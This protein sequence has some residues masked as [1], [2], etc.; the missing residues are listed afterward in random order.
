M[1]PSEELF[2]VAEVAM[3]SPRL[4][5]SKRHGIISWYDDGRRA[6]EEFCEPQWFAGFQKWW[7]LEHGINY[8]ALETAHMGD[9]RIGQGE[10]EEEALI[11]LLSCGE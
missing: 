4:A 6:G 9:S 7:P 11:D 8:F 1:M 2:P 3:D 5:W 10:S